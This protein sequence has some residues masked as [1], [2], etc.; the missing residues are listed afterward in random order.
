METSSEGAAGEDRRRGMK[1]EL[2]TDGNCGPRRG[3]SGTAGDFEGEAV[4]F[5]F[6]ASDP[7]P[8]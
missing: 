1:W 3:N 5:L 2:E 8:S 4:L 6:D 7:T